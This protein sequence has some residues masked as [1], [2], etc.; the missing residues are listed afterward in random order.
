MA[1]VK[2]YDIDSYLSEF[3]A[4]VVSVTQKNDKY[5]IE[6]DRT[7]FFPEAGGQKADSG[8]IDDA[9]VLHVEIINETD[10][11]HYTDK[12]L[13][14]GK[15]V[16]CKIDFPERFKK[17]QIHSGEH[18]VSGV[19][20]ALYGLENVGFHL[21]SEEV[22]L[23]FNAIL[24]REQLD[25][26]E[27]LA[28]EIIYKNVPIKCY[29][30]TEQEL[31]NL[32]YRSKKELEGNIR[33]VEIGEY[34][35][36]ACCAPH[37][38]TTGEVGIIKL[39]AFEKNKQGTRIHLL[40]ASDAL[41]DYREKFRNTSK[42]SALLCA[43]P[44]ETA[45][46]VE[47]LLKEKSDLAYQ[48]TGLKKAIFSL[49]AENTPKTDSPIII[50]EDDLNIPDMRNLANLLIEK[51]PRVCIFSKTEDNEY[52]F[53]CSGKDL[54]PLFSKLKETLECRGGGNDVMIQGTIF[55]SEEKIQNFFS[56]N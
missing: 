46:A 55:A 38:K 22:T 31:Q 51:S 15:K 40:C 37:V 20:H 16:K 17:M 27:L 25:K 23:D 53:V 13:E 28:N 34:D 7:A 5:K 52:N 48:I 45:K 24:T 32:E 14:I 42:I 2:L 56:Q 43:K 10:I 6:L 44:N 1:T 12:P 41:E 26:A 30:P 11:F 54:K 49:K 19:F 35:R 47:N 39:G 8:F 29:Y 33:I 50:F 18:I 9:R 21:G 3:E 36:C 4:T